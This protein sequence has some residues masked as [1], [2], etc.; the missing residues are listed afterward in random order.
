LL[1]SKVHVL[2]SLRVTISTQSGVVSRLRT[3]IKASRELLR[4]FDA[5]HYF[6]V[7]TT[8]G[9]R[10]PAAVCNEAVLADKNRHKTTVTVAL[11]GF[12]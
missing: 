3:A 2:L 4:R 11:A 7:L 6:Y 5:L 1:W 8:S 10:D 9:A 12:E